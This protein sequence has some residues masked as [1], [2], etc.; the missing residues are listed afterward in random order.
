M[1]THKKNNNVFFKCESNLCFKMLLLVFLNYYC[2][3]II[4]ER[5]HSKEKNTTCRILKHKLNNRE[6]F[7][8]K[9]LY[10]KVNFETN[11]H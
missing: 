5:W 4:F 3:N 7:L 1:K 6:V 2:S 9:V 10:S 8:F 11:I